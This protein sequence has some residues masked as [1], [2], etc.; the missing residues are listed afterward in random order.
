MVCLYCKEIYCNIDIILSVGAA[1]LR[2][3]PVRNLKDPRLTPLSV[4]FEMLGWSAR[5]LHTRLVSK[6][7]DFSLTH[8]FHLALAG[9]HSYTYTDF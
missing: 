5:T 3:T 9:T 8:S 4:V 7:N 6:E 2:N 1:Q